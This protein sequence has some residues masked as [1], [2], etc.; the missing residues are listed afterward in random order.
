MSRFDHRRFR[1]FAFSNRISLAHLWIG[2]KRD[3]WP[4]QICLSVLIAYHQVFVDSQHT[5]QAIVV[6][7]CLPKRCAAK[8]YTTWNVGEMAKTAFTGMDGKHQGMDGQCTVIVGARCSRQKPAGNHHCRCCKWQIENRRQTLRTGLFCTWL[9]LTKR[10]TWQSANH[11]LEF[12]C[13]PSG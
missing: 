6:W 12:H 9:K 2:A 10:L 11:R 7:V 1:A 8:I 3:C 4:L 5:S 13:K